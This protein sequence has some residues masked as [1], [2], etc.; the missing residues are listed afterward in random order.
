MPSLQ[1]PLLLIS[2]VR[3]ASA[4]VLSCTMLTSVSSHHAARSPSELP[5]SPWRSAEIPIVIGSTSRDTAQFATDDNEAVHLSS[6][7][8]SPRSS[9]QHGD[10]LAVD[11]AVVAPVSIVVSPPPPTPVPIRPLH[12]IKQKGTESRSFF[13]SRSN[14]KAGYVTTDTPASHSSDFHVV[15]RLGY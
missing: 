9:P 6:N 15:S 14:K 10:D 5:D 11:D 2:R 12:I 4:V 13:E 7:N 8:S 1:N 3:T